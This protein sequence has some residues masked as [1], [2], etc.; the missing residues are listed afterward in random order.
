MAV[1]QRA[2]RAVAKAKKEDTGKTKPAKAKAKT[3]RAKARTTPARAS[4]M[5]AVWIVCDANA[6]G[7]KTFEYPEKNKAEKL[8]QKLTDSK[9]NTHFVRQ[10]KQPMAEAV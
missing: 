3:T 10:V 6:H 8:A 4:R 1:K 5:K 9:G 7:V 2:S